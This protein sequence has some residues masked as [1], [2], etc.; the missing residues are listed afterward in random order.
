[1]PR[2]RLAAGTTPT[3]DEVKKRDEEKKKAEAAKKQAEDEKQKNVKRLEGDAKKIRS[4]LAEVRCVRAWSRNERA[5][6]L[7]HLSEMDSGSIDPFF[8]ARMLIAVDD[9]EAGLAKAREAVKGKTNQ[10]RPLAQLVEV[11]WR[12]RAEEEARKEFETLRGMSSAIDLSIPVYAG[13]LP[14]PWRSGSLRIGGSRLNP[15]RFRRATGP[16]H[17]GPV[18]VESPVRTGL[19]GT[20]AGWSSP[21]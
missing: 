13:W 8:H 14:S 16:R 7:T 2:T 4:V 12:G 11:L 21:T 18:L 19:D 15:E 6:A 9:R 3:P 5:N 10:T 20:G 17:I 1:M